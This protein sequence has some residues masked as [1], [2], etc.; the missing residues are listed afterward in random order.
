MSIKSSLLILKQY[1]SSANWTTGRPLQ[2]TGDEKRLGFRVIIADLPEHT[3]RRI[4][5]AVTLGKQTSISA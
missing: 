1:L 3:Q 4:T 2:L 5:T